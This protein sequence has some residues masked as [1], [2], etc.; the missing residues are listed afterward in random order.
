MRILIFV[1]LLPFLTCAQ[2]EWEKVEPSVLMDLLREYETSFPNS[3]SYSLETG[4]KVFNDYRDKVPVQV[5]DGKLVCKNG[6]ELNI[7][8]MGHL[9]VQDVNLNLTIDTMSKQ[10][11][12]QKADPAFFYRKTVGDYQTFLEITEVVYKKQVSGNKIFLL[13]LRKGYPYHSMEFTFSEK[14]FITQVVIYSNQPYYE[15]TE[16]ASQGRAKIVMDFKNLRKGKAVDFSHF[17]TLKDC[18]QVKDEKIFPIGV[19]RNFE[20]IDLR[21]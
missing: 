9:T 4:Y 16:S 5:F 11:L 6:K 10:V 1:L 12:V 15:E 18:I 19:Y 17:L 7:Y 8:Q 20:L 3:E 21:N 14:N 2:G 13:Q